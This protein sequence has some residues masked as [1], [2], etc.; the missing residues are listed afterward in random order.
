MITQF[1]LVFIRE[2]IVIIGDD[3]NGINDF[4]LYLQQKFRT[5]DL[6][7]LR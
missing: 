6:K 2:D 1:L 7:F 3:A 5:K 4:K